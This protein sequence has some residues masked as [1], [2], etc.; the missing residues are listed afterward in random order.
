MASQHGI[1]VNQSF[2]MVYRDIVSELTQSIGMPQ[3]KDLH[4]SSSHQR[5]ILN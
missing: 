3:S 5:S 4:Q 2:P 1:Q